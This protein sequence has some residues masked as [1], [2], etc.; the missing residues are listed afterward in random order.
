MFDEELKLE[1]YKLKT[2]MVFFD[3]VSD[4]VDSRRDGRAESTDRL[5]S[6]KSN[7]IEAAKREQQNGTNHP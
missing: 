7:F 4:F 6:L 5:F 2:L 3:C 1:D